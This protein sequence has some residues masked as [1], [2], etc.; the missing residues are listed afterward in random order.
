MKNQAKKNIKTQIGYNESTVYHLPSIL[1]NN[2]K[3]IVRIFNISII[4]LIFSNLFFHMS[5]DKFSFLLFYFPIS[6]AILYLISPR[7]LVLS[8]SG[9]QYY[10]FWKKKWKNIKEFSFKNNILIL[11]TFEGK[12]IVVKN[13]DSNI[14]KEVIDFI[15]KKI[16][17]TA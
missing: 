3:P 2:K 4:I 7:T 5:I 12:S 1:F 10:S 16:N 9:I 17:V 14:S 13:I 15:S 11:N 6:L 8:E